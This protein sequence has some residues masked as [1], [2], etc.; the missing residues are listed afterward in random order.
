[1]EGYGGCLCVGCLERRIGRVLRP[2]DF[3]PH[4]FLHLPGTRRLL[5]RQ[6]RHLGQ[7]PPKDGELAEETALDAAL[8]KFIGTEYRRTK[9]SSA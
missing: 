3:P 6:G 2:E 9:A 1:M 8:G 7:R 5:E 4:P